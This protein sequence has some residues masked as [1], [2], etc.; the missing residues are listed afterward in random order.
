[1]V[2]TSARTRTIGSVTD[3]RLAVRVYL[4]WQLTG[5]DESRLHQQ[6]W[7][8]G[9][10][11]LRRLAGAETGPDSM[12]GESQRRRAQSGRYVHPWRHDSDAVALAVHR[13]LRPRGH[14]G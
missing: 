2:V 10:H 14:S 9:K 3:Y 13:R 4:V 11:P 5:T 8:A 1:M 6:D 12:P 7:T